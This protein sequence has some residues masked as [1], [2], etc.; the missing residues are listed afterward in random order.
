MPASDPAN[1]GTWPSAH[2]A[3]ELSPEPGAAAP[4]LADSRAWFAA[5]VESSNDAIIGVTL[6][7][8]IVSWNSGAEHMYGWRAAE[9]LGHHVFENV[10][11]PERAHETNAFLLHVAEG[12]RLESFETE[13]RRKDG[14]RLPVAVTASAVCDPEGRVVGASTIARDISK[15]RAAELALRESEQWARDLIANAPD[16]VIGMDEDGCITEWNGVAAD[17]FG[18]T[19]AEAL[20][21]PLEELIIPEPDRAAHRAGLA[22]YLLRDDGPM[23]GGRTCTTALRRDGRTIPIELTVLAHRVGGRRRFTAFLRDQSYSYETETQL[24]HLAADARGATA[25]ERGE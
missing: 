17:V 1:P 18:W 3:S 5:M 16:A 11:P 21:R 15:R 13:R 25:G 22:R 2:G 9:V 19:D 4:R 14:T 24:R 10:I 20:G 6:E 7:G 12:A 23:V 8:R